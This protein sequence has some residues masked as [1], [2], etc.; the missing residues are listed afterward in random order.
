MA[1]GVKSI[2]SRR[3]RMAPGQYETPLADFLDRLPDYVG[4]YQ[5]QKLEEKKYN[6]ALSRQ[7]SL[8][9]RNEERYQQGIIRD[10]NRLKRNT[11]DGFVKQGR[12][13]Q[14]IS[15]YEYLGDD[16]SAT[17]ARESKVKTEGMNDS[18]VDLRNDL[19]EIPEDSTDI[20]LFKDRLNNFENEYPMEASSKIYGEY[21]GMKD[22]VGVRVK[23]MNKGVIPIG[24][25]QNMDRQGRVDYRALVQTEEKIEDL[26][27]QLSNSFSS[28]EIRKKALEDLESEQKTYQGIL[29]NP[30]Y[31][32][33]TEEQYRQSVI[34]TAKLQSDAAIKEKRNQADAAIKEKRNQ[35]FLDK[36][37]EAD[38]LGL[39]MPN[40]TEGSTFEGVGAPTDEEI[41]AFEESINNMM[42]DEGMPVKPMT[43]PGLNTLQANPSRSTNQANDTTGQTISTKIS[44]P[45]GPYG[46]PEKAFSITAD[47]IVQ[48]KKLEDRSRYTNTKGGDQSYKNALKKSKKI[49]ESLEKDILSIYDPN[50]RQFRY[51]G[52]AE[53][54]SPQGDMVRGKQLDTRNVEGGFLGRRKIPVAGVMSFIEELFPPQI[55]SM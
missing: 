44:P 3:Q 2:Y 53:M 37:L 46:A 23:R 26:S 8:D 24:E 16:V 49:R 55:A 5:A 19:S 33:E 17:A 20:F 45:K 41:V 50:T 4:Q 15:I 30:R 22:R 28:D 40:I 43:I 36:T 21:M 34:D 9:S 12:F 54:F 25:W 42:S 31:T 13:D 39:A 29:L 14:A 51:P 7:K 27:K 32:L 1:N 38:R 35:E 18:F 52:Y 10:E 11:A 48:L 47:K 6:D